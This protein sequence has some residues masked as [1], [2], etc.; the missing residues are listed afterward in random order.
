MKDV[1]TTYLVDDLTVTEVTEVPASPRTLLLYAEAG[2]LG[3]AARVEI[4]DLGIDSFTILSDRQI[5]VRPPAA[6]AGVAVG[7]MKVVVLGSFATGKRRVRLVF[8][9]TRR[10]RAVTG[11]QKLIQQTLRVFISTV[12]SNKWDPS[13]GGNLAALMSQASQ[14]GGDVAVAVAQAAQSTESFVKLRQRGTRLPPDERLRSFQFAGLTVERGE[15]V[16]LVSLSDYAG[17][18]S[19]LPVVL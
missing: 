8:G 18:T 12:R 11:R 16:A 3:S 10:V 2:G 6:L 13:S 4:N 17:G 19:N 1:Q 9:L 7:D 14:A 15:V 5:T